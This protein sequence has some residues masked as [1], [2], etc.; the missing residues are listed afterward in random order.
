MSA[1]DAS[2]GVYGDELIDVY[3][4][5]YANLPDVHQLPPFLAEI[6]PSAKNVLEF[7][8]GTGRLAA[9]LA[10]AGYEVSGIESSA[11]MLDILKERTNHLSVTGHRGDF[12]G[13]VVDGRYDIVL[14]ATNTLF[15]LSGIDEQGK[16]LAQA[17]TQLQ[18]G[19]RLVVETYDP[20][21]YQRQTE[22]SS[23]T[24]PLDAT[25]LLT[26]TT[27]VNRLE[28]RVTVLRSVTS[29]NKVKSFPEESYWLAP[30]ELTLVAER[31]GLFLVSRYADFAQS[32]VAEH[33]TSLVSV[34]RRADDP[35]TQQER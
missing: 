23:L 10:R 17:A 14:I 15:M 13:A 16:A 3:D 9:P 30:R 31:A 27:I 18:P 4:L 19:G 21:I 1:I 28:N 22:P 26:S 7:G 2:T 33:T 35:G 5:L 8:I 24:I 6:V 20:F 25:T 11:K 32:P 12:R 34:F 29:P